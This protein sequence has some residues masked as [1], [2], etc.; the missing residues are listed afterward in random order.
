[1]GDWILPTEDDLPDDGPMDEGE[2][3]EHEHNN[4]I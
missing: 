4:S 1:M 2:A 3:Y